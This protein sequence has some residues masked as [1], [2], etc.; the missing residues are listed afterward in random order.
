MQS[1]LACVESSQA[2][3]RTAAKPFPKG[4][5]GGDRQ[6]SFVLHFG[7]CVSPCLHCVWVWV[8]VCQVREVGRNK[9]RVL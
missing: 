2:E 1:L 5:G 4:E 6:T 3:A 9:M 7:Q 8:Y